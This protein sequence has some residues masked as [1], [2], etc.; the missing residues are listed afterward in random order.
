[1]ASAAVTVTERQDKIDASGLQYTPVGDIASIVDACR[2]T[3]VAGRMRR[4]SFRKRMLQVS[5]GAKLELEL[6]LS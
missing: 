3:F 6:E 1:M 4:V 5:G 2:R